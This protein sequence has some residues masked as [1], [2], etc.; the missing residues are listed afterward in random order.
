MNFN[1]VSFKEFKQ[2]NNLST[3]DAIN[4]LTEK[5]KELKK[6]DFNDTEVN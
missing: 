3:T 4:V 6:T 1:T 2:K 5:L